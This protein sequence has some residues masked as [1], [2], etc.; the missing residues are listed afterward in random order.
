MFRFPRE[1]TLAER[2]QA[3]SRDEPSTGCRIWTGPVTK[4]SHA[5]ISFRGRVIGA[6]RAAWE[7]VHGQ[8][9]TGLVVRHACHNPRC[10]AVAHLSL[11]TAKDN[12]EDR[13]AA[14]RGYRRPGEANPGARYR[15]EQI[16]LVWKLSSEGLGDQQVARRTGVPVRNVNSVKKGWTW[17]VVTG[18]PPRRIASGATN[19]TEGRARPTPGTMWSRPSGMKP[20]DWFLLCS[21]RDKTTGCLVWQRHRSAGGYGQTTYRGRSAASH[22]AVWTELY[23]PIPNK[24]VVR[25][26]CHNRACIEPSHLA[27]GTCAENSAD[28]VKA[29]RSH[30][31]IGE[32]NNN[33]K[34]SADEVLRIR[35]LRLA[36]FRAKQIAR[37]L[38][39]SLP[40]VTGIVVG[41]SWAHL[42]GLVAGPDNR[43]TRNGQAKLSEEIVRSVVVRCGAGESRNAVA[44][45]LG[46]AYG[47]VCAIMN[48]RNWSWLTGIA[49]VVG[50]PRGQYR[51]TKHP[52]SKRSREPRKTSEEGQQRTRGEP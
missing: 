15:R 9:P 28:M 7:L 11:G 39:L 36:G 4:S 32:K 6:H 44:A 23:G 17:N 19:Q 35:D 34:L 52:G 10:I 51:W 29:R 18:L 48:G 50:P 33:A 41:A 22:R 25:H 16:E 12:A 2:L 14:G 49:R 45:S 30:R 42:T 5:L 21:S 24:L 46:V 43:G 40:A 38:G 26:L 27:L 37:E 1:M 20:M 8:V 31:P 13:S 47:T 3:R